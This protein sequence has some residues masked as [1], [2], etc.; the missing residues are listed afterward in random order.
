MKGDDDDDDKQVAVK[1]FSSET[2]SQGRKEFE[3]EV[4]IISRLRHRN[5][6]QL[7]GWCDSSKGLLLV[8]ELVPE[9]SLDK[10]IHNNTRFLTWSERYDSIHPLTVS[11]E[12][13][14]H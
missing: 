9:E 6:V 10:H 4:K 8:Y 7:L 13:S 3:A 12:D 14:F 2:S 11:L 1:K 5:L